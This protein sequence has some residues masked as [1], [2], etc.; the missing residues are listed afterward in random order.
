MLKYNKLSENRIYIHL[1][2]MN[3][4]QYHN[5][6]YVWTDLQIKNVGKWVPL[7]CK[8][9]IE[10]VVGHCNGCVHLNSMILYHIRK[11]MLSN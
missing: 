7:Y 2:P 6:R 9:S 10:W 5:L 11:T 4:Y 1:L 3:K 8:V